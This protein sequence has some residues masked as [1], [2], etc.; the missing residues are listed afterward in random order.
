MTRDEAIAIE[1]KTARSWPPFDSLTDDVVRN[2]A[3]I[4]ID[5]CIALGMLK[6]GEPKSEDDA[7]RWF[8][9]SH[10]GHGEGARF[11]R[12]LFEANYKIVKSC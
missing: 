8:V 3:E 4:S 2:A 7:I 9:A 5:G 10:L 12:K 11:L 1:I 6:I